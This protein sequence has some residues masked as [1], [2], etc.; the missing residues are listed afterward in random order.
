MHPDVV[1]LPAGPR[2]REGGSLMAET[3][4]RPV[5]RHRLWLGLCRRCQT[6]AYLHEVVET[7]ERDERARLMTRAG[8]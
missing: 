1:R 7:I 4:P 5:C 6:V 3:A 2:Q 8:R